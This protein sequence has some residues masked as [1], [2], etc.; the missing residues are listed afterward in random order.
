[1]TVS[2]IARSTNPAG[3]SYQV[4]ESTNLNLGFVSSNVTVSESPDQTGLLVPAQYQRR[5]FTVPTTVPKKFY[6]I[7]ATLD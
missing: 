4:Q 3:A 2:F 5:Q 7:Q 6:R 1:M